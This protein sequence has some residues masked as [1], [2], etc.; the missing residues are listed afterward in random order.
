MP[1][2]DGTGPTGMGPITGR[3]AGRCAE[4][5]TGGYANPGA[6]RGLGRGRGMG[7]RRGNGFPGYGNAPYAPPTQEQEVAELKEQST[8]LSGVLES[9]KNRIAALGA[10]KKDD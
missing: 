7:F 4:N 9:I 10:S 3:A 5:E 1:R 8:H 2:G 6:G